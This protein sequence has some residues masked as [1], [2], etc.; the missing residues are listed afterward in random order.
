MKWHF[1]KVAPTRR[2]TRVGATRG[3]HRRRYAA[4]TEEFKYQ[5]SKTYDPRWADPDDVADLQT[6]IKQLKSAVDRSLASVPAAQ[7]G[8][9]S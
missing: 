2:A 3:R 1:S 9:A 4:L 7:R 6:A 5:T 8:P